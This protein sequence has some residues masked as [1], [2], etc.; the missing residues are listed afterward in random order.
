M[1]KFNFE[2]VDGYKNNGQKIEQSIRYALTGKIIKAD[3]LPATVGADCN[4]Y[5][6]KSARATVCKG[7][8]IDDCRIKICF[9][10]CNGYIYGTLDGIGYIMTKEEYRDF[11]LK[12]GTVTR[13][14]NKNG[15]NAKIRF[16]HET[17]ALR[18]YLDERAE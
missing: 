5:Q 1:K 4:G 9:E 12:F 3:N 6:I 11:V 13:E 17:K 15:G 8:K 14:S 2:I 18:E 16:G 10:R 7:E